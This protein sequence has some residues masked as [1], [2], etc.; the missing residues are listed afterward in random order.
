MLLAQEELAHSTNHL[1]QSH[2]LLKK[3]KIRSIRCESGKLICFAITLTKKGSQVD[4]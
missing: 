3:P 2:I 4:I 1:T